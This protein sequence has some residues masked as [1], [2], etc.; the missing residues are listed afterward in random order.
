[1]QELQGLLKPFDGELDVYPVSKEVGKV[2]NNSPSFII[3]VDSKEN[4][5][6]IANFFSRGGAAAETKSGTAV[7]TTTKLPVRMP[8]LPH[9]ATARP[10]MSA[11]ELGAAPQ[12][13]EPSM[14]SETAT[15]YGHLTGKRT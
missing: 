9:P 1:M 5:N 14:K 12:T 4:K 13:S 6:N 15:K 8:A 7:A 3:P 2:G 10:T 11:A